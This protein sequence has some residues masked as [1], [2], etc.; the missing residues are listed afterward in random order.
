MKVGDKVR[1]KGGTSV[2][3]VIAVNGNIV[4]TEW[5]RRWEFE[6]RKGELIVVTPD[7]ET[8]SD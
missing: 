5:I 6:F 8:T 7:K 4:T 1:M 2:G 3:T